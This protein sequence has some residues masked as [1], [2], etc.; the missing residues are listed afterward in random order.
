MARTNVRVSALIFRSESIL[1]FHRFKNGDEYWVIPGGGVEEGETP[2]EAL[3]RELA[4]E[5][6]LKLI[7][8]S[9]AFELKYTLSDGERLSH[10]FVCVT[11]G[12]PKLGDGPEKQL[13]TE[14]NQYILT[15]VPVS[16]LSRLKSLYPNAAREIQK[17]YKST[18]R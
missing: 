1:L 13:S 17:V 9:D 8:F 18:A 4:E 6:G 5:T 2:A 12:E 16:E 14:T 7:S 15:W 11:E 3:K 10:F